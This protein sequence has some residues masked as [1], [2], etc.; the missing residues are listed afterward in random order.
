MVE[1]LWIEMSSDKLRSLLNT[2]VGYH[3]DKAA[4]YKKQANA[5]SEQVETTNASNNPTQS[6]RSS[7]REHEGKATFFRVLADNVIPNETYRLSE[8][9]CLRI[10]LYS[11]YF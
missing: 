9:N 4:W 7:Q 1:G 5:L 3:S 2:R 6:L 11:R 10:E 8:E